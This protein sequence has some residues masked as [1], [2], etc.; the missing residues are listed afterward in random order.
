MARTV[1]VDEYNAKRN[2]ILDAALRLIGTLGYEQMTIKDLLDEL[3][4]SRGAFY[5]Y[6]DTKQSVLEAL[7][8]RMSAQAMESLLPIVEDPGMSAIEKLRRYFEVSG[9]VK[10]RH[11]ETV[12]TVS[13]TWYSDSNALIRQKVTTGSLQVTAPSIIEPIIRQGVEEGAFSVRHPAQV[14]KVVMGIAVVIGDAVVEALLRGG[15]DATGRAEL[16]ALLF[17]YFDAIERILGAPEG[18]LSVIG[19]DAF[20]DWTP[21]RAER[22]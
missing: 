19:A 12:L 16:D 4:I 3:K 8:D 22:Y 18:S 17:T 6:F 9:Q 13:S 21:S 20:D 1:R 7:V 14:A 2:E 15:A 10:D 5:H 11:R